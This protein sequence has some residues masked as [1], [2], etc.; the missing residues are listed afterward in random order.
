MAIGGVGF[1]AAALGAFLLPSDPAQDMR[2]R[3][4]IMSAEMDIPMKEEPSFLSSASEVL[5]SPSIRLLYLASFFRFCAGLTIGVWGA[6]FFKETYPN[7]AQSYAVLN[8]FIVGIC[9]AV[10]GVVGGALSDF[11]STKSEKW[12]R[13]S[14]PIIGSFLASIAWFLCINA[15]NFQAA[16]IFLGVEY[17]L[18]ENWFG[19]TIAALQGS[20]SRG[21]T[22]QGIFTLTGALGNAAPTLL[23]A[24]Y[25]SINTGGT[26][27]SE[28]LGMLLSAS[29]CIGYVLSA[30]AFALS[31]DAMSSERRFS[32]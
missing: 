25:G 17:L 20:T 23:G 32:N 26:E 31:A 28:E 18:A 14:V 13:L 27:S 16:M 29:V 4:K 9:G 19:P 3:E 5:S 6:T 8:A 2:N 24:Y 7:D 1:A 10:S 22:A 11:L 15:D 12:G 30:F 21:G